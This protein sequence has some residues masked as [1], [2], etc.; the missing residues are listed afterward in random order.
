[1]L[2]SIVSKATKKFMEGRIYSPTKRRYM[3]KRIKQI[4]IVCG[5][6][7]IE[8]KGWKGKHKAPCANDRYGWNFTKDSK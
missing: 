7:F 4:C 6:E 1:M 3:K 2:R 5:I 8:G